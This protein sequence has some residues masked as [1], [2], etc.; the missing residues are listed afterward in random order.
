[1]SDLA[2]KLV[3]AP[4]RKCLLAAHGGFNKHGLTLFDIATQ[5][6]TQFLPLRRA[7]NGLAFS[8]DGKTMLRF[9]R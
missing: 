9:G 4:D 8:R 5:K 1:M 6:Q 2:L 7:G 3:V